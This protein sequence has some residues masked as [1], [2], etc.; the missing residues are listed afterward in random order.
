MRGL[1][2]LALAVITPMTAFAT[3]APPP[4]MDLHP[5]DKTAIV[6]FAPPPARVACEGREVAV[7]D[8]APLHPKAW[9][10]WAASVGGAPAPGLPKLDQSF[11]FSVDA[12]GAM[13]D[14]KRAGGFAPWPND[15]QEATLATWRFAPDAPA[16]GCR[17]DLAVVQTPLAGVAPAKLFEIL[18]FERRDTPPAVREALAQA[19]DCGQAPRRRPDTI[20]Y[21]DLR[22]FN[23]KSLS[24]SWAGVRY[25]IDANG[26][27]RDVRI[28][29][30]SGDAAFG[31]VAASSIAESRFQPGSP[32]TGCYA[33]F[34]AK[35]K[36]TPAPPR[37]DIK[38]FERPGDA[39]D[40]KREAM[41]VPKAK[42]YPATYAKHGVTG[43]AIVR[44]DVA[45]WGQ[46]GNV[47]VVAA[48]P[49]E[50]FGAAARYLVQSA[51][52]SAPATGYRGCLVPIV[53]AIP[54]PVGDDD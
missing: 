36:A 33:A 30:Q 15:E 16:K 3:V 34:T 2:L 18:A 27:V 20:A 9:R 32:R 40:L 24:P 35:P 10:P 41:N 49:S 51:R 38:A 45:P 13:T 25:A 43:W 29:A 4:V 37:P 46:I 54:P 44:F 7:I 14:L 31:D 26:A 28:V 39:C 19:G 6:S 11:T 12:H 21:P 52:P 22:A 17:L 53:Y 8:S 23:D 47:E 1:V 48:Q 50:A 42:T 5:G